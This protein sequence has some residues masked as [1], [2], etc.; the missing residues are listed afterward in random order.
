M[1]ADDEK[2]L[3]QCILSTA[4]CRFI[5]FL[6][7]LLHCELWVKRTRKSSNILSCRYI[8]VWSWRCG[9][10]VAWFCC[11]LMARSGS[12]P[13]CLHDPTHIILLWFQSWKTLKQVKISID[14]HNCNLF[15][16]ITIMYWLCTV[17]LILCHI[18]V[19][20]LLSAVLLLYAYCLY[21]FLLDNKNIIKN[22]SKMFS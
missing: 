12:W 13:L 3:W 20:A 6:I 22:I 11:Q 5:S 7:S 9:C 4:T 16:S 1:G 2:Q 18:Y 10:L 15:C 14:A 8:W 17:P 21:P 19:C